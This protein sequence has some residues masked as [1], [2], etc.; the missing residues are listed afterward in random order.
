ML[1]AVQGHDHPLLCAQELTCGPLHWLVDP[2]AG[3]LR[4]TVRVRH[5]QTDQPAVL[6][7]GAGGTARVL[8]DEPQRALTPGQFAVAYD[9]DLCLGGGTISAVSS[10][11]LSVSA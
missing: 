3:P 7:P 11:L 10:G 1:I 8:F 5:R 4:C 9:G 2:P 6:H